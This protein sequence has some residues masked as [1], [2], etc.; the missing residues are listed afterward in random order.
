MEEL[1]I[2]GREHVALL[3]VVPPAVGPAPI[4]ALLRRGDADGDRHAAHLGCVGKTVFLYVSPAHVA[5]AHGVVAHRHAGGVDVGAVGRGV[6][7]LVEVD[8]P[9]VGAVTVFV[10]YLEARLPQRLGIPDAHPEIVGRLRRVHTGADGAE[11]QHSALLYLQNAAVR[12]VTAG[13][14]FIHV[15]VN[16]VGAGGES[17][18]R[19]Y[20]DHHRHAKQQSQ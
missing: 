12:Y 3:A 7:A 10:K 19:Q 13:V 1:R 2:T 15:A 14:F 20:R 18:D 8:A 16:I 4:E 9:A 11:V 6:V 5:P 17:G